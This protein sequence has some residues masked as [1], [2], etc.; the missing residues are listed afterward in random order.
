MS[1]PVGFRTVISSWLYGRN[2]YGWALLTPGVTLALSL[3]MNGVASRLLE[4]VDFGRFAV[5]ITA[6][7]T[8]IPLASWGANVILVR[9]LTGERD[10]ALAS[11]VRASAY[12][13]VI[14]ATV[15][16]VAVAALLEWLPGNALERWFPR[17]WAPVVAAGAGAS[18]LIELRI[19][20]DQAQFRFDRQF[21]RQVAAALLRLVGV[22]VAAWYWTDTGPRSAIAGYVVALFLLAVVLAWPGIRL[23]ASGARR[24]LGSASRDFV[25]LGLPVTFS[26]LLAVVMTYMDTLMAAAL[27]SPQEL[28]DYAVATRLSL[29]H[30][31]VIGGLAAIA[32]PVAAASAREGRLRKFV[33]QAGLAGTA[34]GIVVVAVLVL[35]APLLVRGVFGAEYLASVSIFVV[36]SLGF[37]LNYAGNPLSQVMYVT[38]HAERLAAIQFVQFALFAPAAWIGASRWGGIGLASARTLT[39]VVAVA[40]ISVMAIVI[41][42]RIESVPATAA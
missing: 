37:L 9:S 29:I 39:N 8:L 22:G 23:A 17:G 25:R 1:E 38:H 33:R 30:V 21:A 3:A 42:R 16:L 7:A 34:L 2:R 12:V 32:L 35:A 27:L 14:S 41:A 24:A 4:P 26:S 40:A 6:L 28:A 18:A 10:A 19:A 36:L 15:A 11:G 20:E 13:I 31:T 5:A